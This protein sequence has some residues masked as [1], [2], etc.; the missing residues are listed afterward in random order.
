MRR[1]FGNEAIYVRSNGWASA[2]RFHHAQS[3]LHRFLNCIW[4][5]T[6]SVNTY[7]YAAAEVIVPHVLGG[8]RE[9]VHP[10]TSWSLIVANTELFVAFG[11][12]PVKNGRIAQGG[13]GRHRQRGAVKEAAAAG[14]RFVNV[15]PLRSDVMAESDA[16][17]LAARPSTD[18]AILLALAHCLIDEGLHDQA[19]LDRYTVGF[20]P[21][22]AY[23]TGERDGVPKTAAWAAAISELDAEVIRNL[24]R[25]MA[26]SRTILSVIWS[27]S[28]QEHGGQPFWA[29]I[30]LATMLGQI[31]LPGGGIGFGYSAVNSVGNEYT[32]V[33]AAD[34]PQG[35]NAVETF[36]PV[37]RIADVLLDP[38]GHL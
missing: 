37:A 38:W 36:I 34:L 1:T 6:R 26:A 20:E 15:S 24:A 11:G 4:G 19:F 5:Y 27:L 28:R 35:K 21:Y 25:R 16:E 17:W 30:A 22:R 13:V 32:S 18:T 12:I 14:V 31:G 9:F 7:S 10:G 3:Q 33:P 8:Y 29:A 23:L 2:G